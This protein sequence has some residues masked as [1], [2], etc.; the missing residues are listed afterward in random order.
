MIH[1][2]VTING[3]LFTSARQNERNFPRVANLGNGY[4]DHT[5]ITPV[6][7][8]LDTLATIMECCKCLNKRTRVYRA[9]FGIF[10]L[11][12]EADNST[13]LEWNLGIYHGSGA[14]I[15][16]DPRVI[17]KKSFYFSSGQPL[18]LFRYVK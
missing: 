10:I 3:M 13:T 17:K 8:S 14:L 15:N 7:C 16:I 1:S 18:T 11:G 5:L 2:Q 4:V 9:Q 12:C 6:E